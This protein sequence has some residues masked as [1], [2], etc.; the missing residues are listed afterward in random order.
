MNA[1]PPPIVYFRR[2]V[3]LPRQPTGHIANVVKSTQDTAARLKLPLRMENIVWDFARAVSLVRV[4]S[5]SLVF[6]TIRLH[7]YVL[8][9]FC[10]NL[11]R[12]KCPLPRPIS[13][14]CDPH[15]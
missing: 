11:F 5:R 13:T 12:R 9:L 15:G 10:R 7:Y 14:S 1:P 8:M 2:K 6:F 3:P 4:Q